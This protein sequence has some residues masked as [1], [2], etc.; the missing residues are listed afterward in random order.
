MAYFRLRV[1]LASGPGTTSTTTSS[2]SGSSSDSGSGRSPSPWADWNEVVV[3]Q[4]EDIFA[5]LPGV[6]R[7][8]ER[9]R[10][11]E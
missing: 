11:G 3:A 10:A 7:E 9:E 1:K 8:W 6:A 5:D 4:R 2:G